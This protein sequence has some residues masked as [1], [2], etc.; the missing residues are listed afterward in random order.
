M[1]AAAQSVAFYDPAYDLER[2]A[3]LKQP[4][5]ATTVLLK[6]IELIDVLLLLQKKKGVI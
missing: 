2:D 5:K 3:S 4:V 1:I 6:V